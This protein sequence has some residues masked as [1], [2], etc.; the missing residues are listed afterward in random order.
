MTGAPLNNR[1][2]SS[3][4][5]FGLLQRPVEPQVHSKTFFGFKTLAA[6]FQLF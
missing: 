4:L 1:I 3:S 5:N 6:A 2:R